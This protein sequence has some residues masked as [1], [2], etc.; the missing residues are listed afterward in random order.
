MIEVKNLVKKYSGVVVL[1]IPDLTVI[2]GESF[3]LVGNNG[4]GKTTL[5]SLILDLRRA[6]KGSVRIKNHDVAKTE[7]WKNFTGSYI[8]ENFLID[9]LTPEEYFQFIANL[10]G[11]SKGDLQEFYQKY[12]DLF[13]GEIMGKKKYIR[14]L[15]K[16]NQKKVGIAGS[17]ISKPEVIVLDEPFSNL[18]PSSQIR[19]KNILKTMKSEDSVTMLISS[20]DLNH[21]TEVC[22]RI[23]ILDKGNIVHDLQTGNKTLKDLETYFAV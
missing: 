22:G 15:S 21:V 16:G 20:H 7:D 3:G 5:F 10:H 6:T 17:L 19:L 4:A 18:D 13:A 1:D 2:K 8:D 11:L 9:F 12:E 23:V 14:E